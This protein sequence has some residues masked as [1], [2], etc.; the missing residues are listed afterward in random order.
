M[1]ITTDGVTLPHR[2]SQTDILFKTVDLRVPIKIFGL[3]KMQI[4]LFLLVLGCRHLEWKTTMDELITS[5]PFLLVIIIR[6]AFKKLDEMGNWYFV[7]DINWHIGPCEH[8]ISNLF[9]IHA[10]MSFDL[11]AI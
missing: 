1:K 7:L 4:K 10:N 8:Y 3:I 2:R 5:N 6:Q 11:R 9:H